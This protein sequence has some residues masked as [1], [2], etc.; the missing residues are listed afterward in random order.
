LNNKKNIYNFEW[1]I[2]LITMNK[3]QL[4]KISKLI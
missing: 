2:I 1:N 3:D 4:V